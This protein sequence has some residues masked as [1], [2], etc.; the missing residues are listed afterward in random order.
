M[1]ETISCK[2]YF[3]NLEEPSIRLIL[4]NL[5][6]NEGNSEKF[7]FAKSFDKIVDLYYLIF[8]FFYILNC[9]VSYLRYL[10]FHIFII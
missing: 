9:G 3:D 8:Q 2:F 1:L 4:K 7:I 10:I 5:C 6:L